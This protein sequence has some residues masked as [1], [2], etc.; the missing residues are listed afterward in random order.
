M[1]SK[2]KQHWY[3]AS[4]KKKLIAFILSMLFF[5]SIF[6]I[7]MLFITYNY[8]KNF[9]NNINEYF[10][11]NRLQQNNEQSSLFLQS[12]FNDYQL[13]TLYELNNNIDEFNYILSEIEKKPHSVEAYLLIRSIKNSFESYSQEVSS[14]VRKQRD[15]V[16]DFYVHYNNAVRINQYLDS[17]IEQLLEISLFEGSVVYGRLVARTE[18]IILFACLVIALVLF[19]CLFLGIKLSNYLI[20]PIEELAYMSTQLAKGNMSVRQVITNSQDEVGVLATS[21]NTMSESIRNLLDDLDK[22]ALIEKKLYD[23]ELKNLHNRELLKEAQFLSLQSQINPHFLFNTLNSISRVI[24]LNRPEEG[25]DLLAA[26]ASILRYNMG[27]SKL[28]VTLHD[29]LEIIKQY[30]NI[31]HFRF[32]D[33]LKTQ[34]CDI[35]KNLGAVLMPRFTLQ[36][37]VENSIIHGLEPKIEGGR[38]KIKC[39]K[40]K[41]ALIIKIIDS[42]VGMAKE[43]KEAILNLSIKGTSG[44]TN[45]IGLANVIKRLVIFCGNDDC[46]EIKSRFGKGTITTIRIPIGEKKNVHVINR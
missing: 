11:I 31:Q 16:R 17:Y 6:N 5:V 32:G 20:K 1:F 2:I 41:E 42:G 4:I 43:T 13:N 9:S 38:L 27:D 28:Y 44:Q 14:A 23:E 29:E 15:G 45:S 3:K 46:L 34:I 37:I 26:L 33:R 18:N 39:Y 25:I 10:Q 21:F 35:D 24:S 7:Y 8:T 12:Y 19:A 40:C 36:P 22:K 30:L